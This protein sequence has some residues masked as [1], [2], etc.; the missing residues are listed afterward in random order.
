MAIFSKESKISEIET[1]ILGLQNFIET[2][3]GTEI[4]LDATI[5]KLLEMLRIDLI[6]IKRS[7]E[8]GNNMLEINHTRDFV[9]HSKQLEFLINKEK[10][11][12]EELDKAATRSSI[13][14]Y[15]ARKEAEAEE[16]EARFKALKKSKQRII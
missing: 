4:K 8:L 12:F 1:K 7:K 16:R 2:R 9:E 5:K 15:N 11:R 13:S 14:A 6:N 10:Q 3:L